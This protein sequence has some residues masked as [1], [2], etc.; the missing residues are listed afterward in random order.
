MK[1]QLPSTF[2]ETNGCAV[3]K[4]N[5]HHIKSTIYDHLFPILMMVV[6]AIGMYFFIFND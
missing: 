4:F 1:E 2:S 3:E 5:S 6:G